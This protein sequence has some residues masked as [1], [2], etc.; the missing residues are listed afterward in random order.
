MRKYLNS[1]LRLELYRQDYELIEGVRYNSSN[2][3]FLLGAGELLY[4]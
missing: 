3:C 1:A 2:H 4:S